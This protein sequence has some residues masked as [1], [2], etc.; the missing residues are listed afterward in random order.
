MGHDDLFDP[1]PQFTDA[2]RAGFYQLLLR[3][4]PPQPVRIWFGPPTDPDTGEEMDRSPRWQM[5][6]NGQPALLAEEDR[7]PLEVER[8]KLWTDVWPR[9]AGAPIEEAEYAYLVASIE[10]ARQHEPDNPFSRPGRRID[11]DTAAMPL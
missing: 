11:L 1:N 9:C 2:P 3:G 6:V 10:H 8:A 7:N 4:R 5:L